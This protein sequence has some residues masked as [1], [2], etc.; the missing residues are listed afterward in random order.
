MTQSW[1]DPGQCRESGGI[2]SEKTDYAT[3]QSGG[4]VADGASNGGA[5]THG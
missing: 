3:A 4:H 5:S 2:E 1:F